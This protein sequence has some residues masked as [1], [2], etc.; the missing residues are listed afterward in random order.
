MIDQKLSLTENIDFMY[1]KAQQRLYLLRKLKRFNISLRILE[2]VYRSLI[3][4]FLTLNIVTW[5][6]NLA[7]QNRTKLSCAVSIASKI[8]GS[9]QL[10]LCQL[11]QVSVKR[12][13]CQ[14]LSDTTHPLKGQVQGLGWFLT[15]FPLKF[16]K[17]NDV[18]VIL[19][20]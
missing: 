14:I 3:E 5:Y 17:N 4:S 9:Q 15:R 1:K 16:F 12:K 20:L 11:Y 19:G 2:S 6:G 13:T 10:H 7:V 8:V 18:G